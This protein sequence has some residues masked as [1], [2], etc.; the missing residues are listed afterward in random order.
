MTAAETEYNNLVRDGQW[1]QSGKSSSF[2]TRQ[3][4]DMSQV[5]C[6]NCGKKGHYARDCTEPSTG[7]GGRGRGWSGRGNGRGGRGRGNGRGRGRGRGGRGGGRGRGHGDPMRRPP[8]VNDPREDN[9][10]KWC[11]TCSRWTDHFT[12]DCNRIGQ[13]NTA[14]ATGSNQSTTTGNASGNGQ[15]S[16]GNANATGSTGRHV[17]FEHLQCVA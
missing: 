2:M 12:N 7:Q 15:S 11:G 10:G 4:R 1:S 17:T 3:N 6:Y 9:R 13:A 16:S 5:E 14:N 8:G